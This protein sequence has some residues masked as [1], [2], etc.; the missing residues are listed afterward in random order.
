MNIDDLGRDA[1]QEVRRQAESIR[2]SAP[3]LG[4]KSRWLAPAAASAAVVILA[5]A[6]GLMI[7]DQPDPPIITRPATTT[8]TIVQEPTTTTTPTTTITIAV[9]PVL[10]SPPAEPHIQVGLNDV[11]L[12]LSLEGDVIGHVQP[13]LIG[14]EFY[15]FR[16]RRLTEDAT[17]SVNVPDGCQVDAVLEPGTRWMVFCRQVTG[18][19]DPTIA[20]LSAD[21]TVEVI[22]RIPP[23]PVGSTTVGHWREVFV[24]NDGAILAQYSGECEIP[25]AMFIIDGVARHASGEGFWDEQSVPNS[26]TY[27]WLPDGRALVWTE[28]E[29][30]CGSPDSDP[31]LYAYN[32]DGSRQLLLPF[33]DFP[34]WAR[35][36]DSATAG[37]AGQT[38]LRASF[39]H[40]IFG[41]DG[42]QYVA[43][44]LLSYASKTVAWDRSDGFVYLTEDGMLR[45]WR[46]DRDID[47]MQ[48]SATDISLGIVDVLDAGG[49]VV[50]LDRG[51]RLVA[52]DLS[53]G[54]ERDQPP[55]LIR[56]LDSG[57]LSWSSWG[58][59]RPGSIYRW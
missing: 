52:V 18:N 9:G 26:L 40:G 39:G 6:L 45:W 20:I 17:S 36:A 25:H 8:T 54:E 2:V 1:A 27:G 48:F 50:V 23:G 14:P 19:P 31:G 15:Q 24:R 16:Q 32:I 5:T 56:R 3:T 37:L 43:D 4:R 11:T 33:S 21:G 41:S 34:A 47:V 28:H 51:G 38:W 7:R 30:G 59:L 55:D 44:P 46:P 10:S 57:G 29:S 13:P 35:V 49:R 53:T 58:R 22:G 12:I 42:N